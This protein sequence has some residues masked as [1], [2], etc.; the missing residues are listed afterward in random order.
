M[1]TSL[2]EK[3][4]RKLTERGAAQ[5]VR[6]VAQRLSLLPSV[7]CVAHLVQV[8]V[9]V[10]DRVGVGNRVRVR[11]RVRV[12]VRVRVRASGWV[13]ASRRRGSPCEATPPPQAPS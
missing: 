12:R 4:P 13:R 9:R 6:Y 8:R 11:L 3:E 7:R 1:G 2:G 10:G 5:H